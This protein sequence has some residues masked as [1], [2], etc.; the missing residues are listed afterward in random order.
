MRSSE[1]LTQE[2]LSAKVKLPSS[3]IFKDTTG[4]RRRKI[5]VL[6]VW[7]VFMQEIRRVAT[8]KGKLMIN[9]NEETISIIYL[10]NTNNKERE[11][12]LRRNVTELLI[13]ARHNSPVVVMIPKGLS[14]FQLYQTEKFLLK[15]LERSNGAINLIGMTH[16]VKTIILN[17][18]IQNLLLR[19]NYF[20]TAT[21]SKET[22]I[23]ESVEYFGLKM[24]ETPA[25][26][27]A[28]KQ[29]MIELGYRIFIIE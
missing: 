14:H 18:K 4:K 7:S 6:D 5:T 10:K 13:F 11:A 20:I 28:V 2:I 15:F 27:E 26:L 12:V 21:N 9:M 17:Q 23:P 16:Y 19:K 29:M 25:D 3:Y 8:E 22:K 24:V 1:S